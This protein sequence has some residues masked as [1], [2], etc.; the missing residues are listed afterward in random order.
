M[1]LDKC[2]SSFEELLRRIHQAV[3]AVG[4]SYYDFPTP[5]S[6]L[7]LAWSGFRLEDLYSI[8]KSDVGQTSRSV[9]C[10]KQNRAIILPAEAANYIALYADLEVYETRGR[11]TPFLFRT[12][13]SPQVDRMSIARAITR[14]NSALGEK[15]GVFTYDN[16]YSSGVF[17]R[18]VQIERQNPLPEY[19]RNNRLDANGWK[20]YEQA[21]ERTFE[22][23]RQVTKTVVR[24]EGYKA[25]F[26]PDLATS[27]A[28]IPT[29]EDIELLKRLYTQGLSRK[30]IAKKTGGTTSTV[31]GI[32]YSHGFSSDPELRS[33]R[34]KAKALKLENKKKITD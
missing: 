25:K 14:M 12:G 4:R 34:K 26:Y 8:Q 6:A 10:E 20:R 23:I 18:A 21:F 15:N 27:E 16:V 30:E 11:T 19:K 33:L 13:R 31:R 5:I 2:F 7:Y 1:D 17:Y 22:D 3:S 28:R 24:Y 32:L 9:W 29:A